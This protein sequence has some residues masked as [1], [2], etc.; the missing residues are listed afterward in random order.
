MVFVRM[1]EPGNVPFFA[2]SNLRSPGSK[3]VWQD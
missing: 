3:C 2:L 1:E